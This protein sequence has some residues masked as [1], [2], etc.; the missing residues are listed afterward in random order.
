MKKFILILGV[1]A[2]A[3]PRCWPQAQIIQQRAEQI[4]DRNNQ[5]QA[6]LNGGNGQPAPPPQGPEPAATS[7]P[8]AGQGMDPAQVR[9][10]DRLSAD[11]GALKPGTAAT[12]DQKTNLVNDLAAL[13]KGPVKP[14]RTAMAKSVD[15]LAAALNEKP[16]TQPQLAKLARSINVVVNCSR[17]DAPHAQTWVAEAQTVFKSAGVSAPAITSL[18]NDLGLIVSDIQRNKSK[19]YQ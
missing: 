3:A 11:L 8:P 19:L 18:G 14:S 17:L 7:T 16:L 9:L 13:S 15:D 12:A 5:T 10:I 1:A 2:I 6:E 4:R